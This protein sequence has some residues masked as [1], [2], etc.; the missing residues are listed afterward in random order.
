LGKLHT[1]VILVDFN[2]FK[3]ARK[4]LLLPLYP[5]KLVLPKFRPA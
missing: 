1:T 4:L 5:F 2:Q 3:E